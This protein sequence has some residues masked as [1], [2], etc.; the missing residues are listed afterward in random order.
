VY[1]YPGHSDKD[2]SIYDKNMQNNKP[3]S[4]YILIILSVEK[5][6]QHSLVTYAFYTD[7]GSIRSSVAVDYRF[8]IVS[9]FIVGLL[10][11][12]NIPFLYQRK[13]FSFF[14]LAGLAFFDLIGEF[15]AQGTLII[16]ITISFVVA[17]G[18]LL[19]LI[20]SRKS[21]IPETKE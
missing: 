4:L 9:G 10:F 1:N 21:L 20:L 19:I 15:A 5:F 8:L 11:L 17:A 13:R 12:V 18:I 7:S 6:I 16:D 14:L 2:L 3:F